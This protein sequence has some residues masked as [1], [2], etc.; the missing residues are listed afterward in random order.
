ME[1]VRPLAVAVEDDD[2]AEGSPVDD[3]GFCSARGA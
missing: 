3:V 1:G 2:E